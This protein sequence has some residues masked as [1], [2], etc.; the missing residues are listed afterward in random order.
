MRN[1]VRVDYF[2]F[3]FFNTF[4]GVFFATLQTWMFFHRMSFWDGTRLVTSWRRTILTFTSRFVFLFLCLVVSP[5]KN[6]ICLGWGGQIPGEN[7]WLLL[8][9]TAVLADQRELP[10]EMH[11]LETRVVEGAAQAAFVK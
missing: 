7:P 6:K 8:L 2:S 5:T 4:D 11:A 9:H 3:Q 10:I 1:Y